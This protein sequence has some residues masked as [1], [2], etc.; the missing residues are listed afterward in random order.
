MVLLQS[1]LSAT[2]LAIALIAL[3]ARFILR[4]TGRLKRS[5]TNAPRL[6]TK[7]ARYSAVRKRKRR[8]AGTPQVLTAPNCILRLH[9]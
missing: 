6:R 2:L 3:V 4:G 8:V 5:T 9:C 7:A 1:Q